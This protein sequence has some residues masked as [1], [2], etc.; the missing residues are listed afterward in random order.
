[1]STVSCPSCDSTDWLSVGK[2]VLNVDLDRPP[3]PLPLGV[4]GIVGPAAPCFCDANG[5]VGIRAA[6]QFVPMSGHTHREM[7]K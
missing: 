5:C 3:R 7:Y 6:D 1:M 2:I 4:D